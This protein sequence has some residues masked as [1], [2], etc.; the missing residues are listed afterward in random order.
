MSRR[1]TAVLLGAA[2]A[3]FC[4]LASST[5]PRLGV[6]ADEVVHLTGGYTYWKFNDY[7]M[8]PEN[9]TLPMRLAA[10]PWL[11][12]DLR[13][14]PLTDPNWIASNVTYYGDALFFSSGN[15]LEAMLQRARM[16]IALVGAF[17]VW[18][19]W[20]WA[21]GLFGQRAGWV[22]LALAIFCPA[23]LAHSGLATSDI[24]MTGCVLGAL[25]AV[26]LL[27]H[28]ITWPRLFVAALACGC[29]FLSKMS[30]VL[31]V[32]LIAA[33]V[34]LRWF[35][36]API[37]V[38]LGGS[39]R[40]LRRRWAVAG[41][42]IS[43]TVAVA[44]GSL[45]V[46]WAAYG[47]RFEGFNRERSDA[48]SYFFSWD[49]VLER[50]VIPWPSDSALDELRPARQPLR[51]SAMTALIDQLR[52]HR[53]LP[54]AY[55]W[56]FAHTYKF[57]RYRPAF[58]RG[59]HRGTGWKLFFPTALLFKSTLPMLAL[60]AT[61]LGALLWARRRKLGRA[62][63]V[64]PWAYR[65]APLILFFVVYWAM[66]VNMALNIGHRHILPTYPILFVFASASV[67]FLAM[68][69]RRLV[70]AAIIAALSLHAL[71][72]FLARPFYLSYFQP[73]AG[74][75]E[76]GYRHFVDSSFDWGQGLPDL[77]RWLEKKKA[78]GDATPVFLTY[79]GAD[80][81]RARRLDVIRFGDEATDYGTRAFPAH[82]RAGWFVISA[83]HFQRVY[84]PIRGEWSAR[85]EQIYRD[86]HARL[87][88]AQS[89]HGT[90]SEAE[91]AQ[92]TRDAQD[93]ELLQFCRL[94]FFLRDVAPDDIIGGSLLAFKLSDA[95]L[96]RALF[97]PPPSP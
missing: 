35:R 65:A 80:S 47:F 70:A 36:P 15:P 39:T 72:S 51:P 50:E 54:E 32:P 93:Y 85:A 24:G 53:L 91:R 29:A 48:R 89:R 19:T 66:A 67:I 9:G 95:E 1:A 6:T 16:M 27:L 87:L 11:A 28:R 52:E 26:W 71:E 69:A 4:W 82:V 86:V 43:A 83:T 33:L 38:A 20:R 59:E 96:Q 30:G 5:S 3:L 56:G 76:R 13:H 55:L 2:L 62:A 7:R 23:M 78:H 94:T 88:A 42:T 63:G 74:G 84:L 64:R 58:F 40:W 49:A 21:R 12:M 68:S 61:G 14:P 92:F 34:L 37:L 45:V 8:H 17:T 73:L 25:S 46:L 75:M 90:L 97:G 41:A 10:L 77:T 81:P 79:F 31:I 18:L 22:A 60:V 57:S 44:A